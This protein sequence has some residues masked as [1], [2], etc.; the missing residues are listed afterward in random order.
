MKVTVFGGAGAIGRELVEDLVF[1]GYQVTVVVP[2]WLPTPAPLSD[3]VTVLTEDPT[4]PAVV[5]A[6]V[7]GR[8]AVI[9]TLDPRLHPYDHRQPLVETTRQVVAAM[10]RCGTRRYIGYSTPVVS[11][12]PREHPTAH[13][14][15]H[16]LVAQYFHRTSYQ[17]LQAMAQLATGSGLEWTL[18]RFLHATHAPGRGL[19]YVGYV[20]ADGVGATAS[21]VDIAG[22]TAAQVMGTAYLRDAPA[23]SN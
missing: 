18:V 10:G 15:A 12:C 20:G 8:R 19:R 7:A 21:A 5:E 13:I 4:D 9:N 11:L 1:R 16:R 3:G 6:V 2:A 14:R 23:G 17:Q 22:F